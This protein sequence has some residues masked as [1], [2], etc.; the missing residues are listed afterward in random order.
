MA[1]KPPSHARL[2]ALDGSRG[3]DIAKSAERLAAE[4]REL[5]VT[6][7]ISRWDASGLFG[8]LAQ[9][10]QPG[11]ASAR[12]LSLLYAADLAFRLR[13]EIASALES[14]AVVIAAP[15]SKLRSRSVLAAACPNSGCASCCGLRRCPMC[16]PWLAN[17]SWIGAGSRGSTVV[18]RNT[19]QRCLRRRRH[20]ACRSSRAPR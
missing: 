7:V 12:T 10:D 6:C 18:I 20:G 13:W 11:T 8:E 15:Y 14:G 17:A 1:P 9:T 4:L 5:G 19:V 3:A 16:R 2:I